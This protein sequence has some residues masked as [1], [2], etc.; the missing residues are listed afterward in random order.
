MSERETILSAIEAANEEAG[1]NNE[2]LPD[3]VMIPLSWINA[4]NRGWLFL[5]NDS[6][7]RLYKGRQESSF[8][9]N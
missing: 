3:I 9:G 6:C 5:V 8:H 4:V 2:S 1:V 7:I